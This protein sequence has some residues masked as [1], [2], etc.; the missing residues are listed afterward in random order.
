MPLIRLTVPVKQI[1]LTET[2]VAVGF[3]LIAEQELLYSLF[4]P[5]VT[6]DPGGNRCLYAGWS[7]ILY[8]GRPAIFSYAFASKTGGAPSITS[9][10]LPMR[11][12]WMRLRSFKV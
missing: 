11:F 5:L 10:S 1:M 8:D 12:S 3:N 7:V 4:S 2:R 9:S 6:M